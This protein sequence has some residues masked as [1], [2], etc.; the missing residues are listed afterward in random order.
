MK[1]ECCNKE[2]KVVIAPFV[3]DFNKFCIYRKSG[4]EVVFK[5]VNN[6]IIKPTD[7]LLPIERQYIKKYLFK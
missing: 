3:L 7:R 4:V 2:V 6:Q 5:I 1:C